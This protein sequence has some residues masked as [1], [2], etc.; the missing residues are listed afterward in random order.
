[1]HM[2]NEWWPFQQSARQKPQPQGEY[3]GKT[4]EQMAAERQQKEYIFELLNSGKDVVDKAWANMR[5]TDQE[6]FALTLTEGIDLTNNGLLSRDRVA[7]FI[8]Q[9]VFE[10]YKGRLGLEHFDAQR[11]LIHFRFKE[12]EK[13]GR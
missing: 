2:P 13:S 7:D 9:W 3:V 4:K 11:R 12:P 6:V 10:T 8:R 5:Q 1:M